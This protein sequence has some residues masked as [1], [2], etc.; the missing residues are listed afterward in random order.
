MDH[1]QGVTQTPDGPL[2]PVAAVPGLPSLHAITTT[3]LGAQVY[4][5]TASGYDALDWWRRLREA[6]AATGYWPLLMGHGDPEYLANSYEYADPAGS[7][8][9][10]DTLD[11]TS[12]LTA[13]GEDRLRI[14]G[15]ELAATTLAEL[16]GEGDWPDQARR[17]GFRLPFGPHGEPRPVTITLVPA[18]AG[19][20]VPAVLHCGGWNEY[21][22]PAEHAAILRTWENRYG[23]ELVVLTGATAEFAVGRPPRTKTEAL[24][25]AWEYF[26]YNDGYYDLYGADNLTELAASLLD[27]AVWLAWWD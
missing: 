21:P 13:R 15:P 11:G 27:A 23:A 20:Q 8:A 2:F 19:W 5:F 3:P 17:P 7:I 26:V 1:R 6:H 12:I 10:A 18:A 25:L 16:R 22:A 24:A 4:G 14:Y 9:L